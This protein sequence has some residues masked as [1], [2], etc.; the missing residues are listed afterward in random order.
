M[1]ASIST[2]QSFGADSEVYSIASPAIILALS[3]P[4]DTLSSE[5]S[6]GGGQRRLMGAPFL[7]LYR[8]VPDQ[9]I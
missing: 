1:G 6:K 2:G 7:L 5:H 9:G 8:L 3:K 4:S